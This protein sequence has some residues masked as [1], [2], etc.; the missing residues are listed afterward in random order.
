MIKQ[1]KPELESNECG[2]VNKK[3]KEDEQHM[4]Q[5]DEVSIYN[6]CNYTSN[7]MTNLK[8]HKRSC[9]KPNKRNTKK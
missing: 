6:D 9:K 5:T 4:D 3:N 2:N 8:T 7:F 1:R